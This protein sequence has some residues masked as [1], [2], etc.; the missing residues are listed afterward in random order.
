MSRKLIK[1]TSIWAVGPECDC[2]SITPV[3]YVDET[4]SQWG[5]QVCGMHQKAFV[6]IS[7]L[8]IKVVDEISIGTD[9]RER[10][11]D[12]TLEEVRE[13]FNGTPPVGCF[14]TGPLTGLFLHSQLDLAIECLHDTAGEKYDVW[15][16]E[17]QNVMHG[18]VDK[19]RLPFLKFAT[20]DDVRERCGLPEMR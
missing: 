11:L 2:I 6:A 19:L 8:I 4:F 9:A 3:R 17:T 16:K 10:I 15:E 7:P 12:R 20:Y 18:L 1:F 5:V 14:H 13:H